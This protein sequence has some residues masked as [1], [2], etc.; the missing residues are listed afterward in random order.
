MI[1]RSLDLKSQR[2]LFLCSSQLY[3][4]WHLHVPDHRDWQFV[5]RSIS[6]LENATSQGLCLEGTRSYLCI[7]FKA[8]KHWIITSQK[9]KQSVRFSLRRTFDDTAGWAGMTKDQLWH[10]LTGAPELA[11][12]KMTCCSRPNP[13]SDQ[14]KS[15]AQQT[16][17]LLCTTKGLQKIY[18]QG[19]K[20]L[21]WH[22]ADLATMPYWEI[23][24]VRC[25]A[26]PPTI[27]FDDMPEGVTGVQ[28]HLISRTPIG[29]FGSEPGF[30]D[31]IMVSSDYEVGSFTGPDATFLPDSEVHGFAYK[32]NVDI[33]GWSPQ[34]VDEQI[35][36][37]VIDVYRKGALRAANIRFAER[38][39][40]NYE[41]IIDRDQDFD[42][43]N[44]FNPDGTVRMD[45]LDDLDF[46]FR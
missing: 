27:R 31:S 28:A 26:D 1:T 44:S 30:P 38:H 23:D 37:N 40:L 7:V 4:K 34:Q 10:R 46:L 2:N 20:L 25:I 33:D 41:A 32:G 6:L 29:Q 43:L 24:G 17:D 11:F 35:A 42:F 36:L 13:T 16:F 21:I 45:N 8:Q 9:H 39:N 14:L 12:A 15:L 19:H 22:A 18:I 5:K 3:S